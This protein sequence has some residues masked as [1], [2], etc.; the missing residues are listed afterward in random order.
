MYSVCYYYYY[1]RLE[2][3]MHVINNTTNWKQQQHIRGEKKKNFERDFCSCLPTDQRRDFFRRRRHGTLVNLK[4]YV[5]LEKDRME[6]LL[7]LLTLF[8]PILLKKQTNGCKKEHE[9]SWSKQSYYVWHHLL[10]YKQTGWT[11]LCCEKNSHQK[12]LKGW[13]HEGKPLVFYK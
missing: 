7:R 6:K 11:V 1:T 8:Y 5:N 3:H 9:L 12:S 2:I 10:G 13:L 4:K